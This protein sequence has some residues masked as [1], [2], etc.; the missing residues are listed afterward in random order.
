[1]T[2]VIVRILHPPLA[3]SAGPLE[4]LLAEA[5]LSGAERH[6]ASFGRAGAEDVAIVS[7]PADD[8]PFGA[9]LRRLAAIAIASPE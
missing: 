7:K 6:V 5:R 9:R 8:T 2:R 4:R 3:P 1:M